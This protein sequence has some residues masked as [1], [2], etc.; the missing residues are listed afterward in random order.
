MEKQIRDAGLGELL[1]KEGFITKEALLEALDEQKTSNTRLD[2]ILVKRGVV[3]EFDIAKATG[4]LLG[5]P[6]AAL[7]A[8]EPE[9]SALSLIPEN[10]ASRLRVVPLKIDHAANELILAMADP[11]DALAIDEVRILS[12]RGVSAVAAAPSDIAKAL[13]R[14][15]KVRSSLREA[16]KDAENADTLPG[17][18]AAKI[19][20]TAPRDISEAGS[21]PVIKLVNGILEQGVR[22]KASDIHIEPSEG[23]TRVR[24]RIDGALSTSF[25]IPPSLHMPLLARIKVLSSMDIAEKRRPQDGRILIKIAD[26]KIDLRVS[27]LPSIFGEKAVLR[28]LDQ[29]RKSVTLEQLGF[30]GEQAGRMRDAISAPNG[31][32]LV[33]GPTGSGKSTTLYSLLETINTPGVNIITL[34]DPVEFTIPGIT[35]VQINEKIGLTFGGTLRSVLRQ[36]P[37]KLMVGE[38][39]DAETAQLAVRAALTGH[40]ILSTLHTNDAVTAINRLIDMGAP[41]F[42]I[43]SSLRGA[44]AQRLVRRLCPRCRKKVE[45]DEATERET[46][47]KAGTA[48]FAPTGCHACRHTGYSGRT[49][50]AEL[51]LVGPV[52]RDMIN[53]SASES[54]MRSYLENNGMRTLRD[55]ARA[56]VLEG[57]T[58]IEEMLCATM[59]YQEG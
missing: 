23:A 32:F 34:E 26:R 5:L 50:I 3:S 16:I 54:D 41:R 19:S 44:A 8:I 13:S 42:L 37:D 4:K 36:D 6:F 1:V 18:G 24:M 48:V 46:G 35:Q 43:A 22:E 52:L 28:L 30:S 17:A 51:M 40:L 49:A 12:K 2:E 20:Q 47:I 27:T 33:T 45:A 58:S 56:K 55:S 57:V 11:S 25:E 29:S 10:V 14:Y 53:S 21:A 39:R 15:Y 59:T 38:I 7:S 31:I 9:Q